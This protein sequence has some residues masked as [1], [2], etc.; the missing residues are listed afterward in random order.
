MSDQGSTDSDEMTVEDQN[1]S[2][3]ET[4]DMQSLLSNFMQTKE[5]SLEELVGSLMYITM[6]E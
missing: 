5:E 4:D 1:R 2:N 6:G 3:A